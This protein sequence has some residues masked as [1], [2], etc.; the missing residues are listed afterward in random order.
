MTET[1]NIKTSSQQ[2]ACFTLLKE[3]GYDV[4]LNVPYSEC[5][6][7][8]LIT[9]EDGT[10]IDFEYDGTYWH[11]DMRNRD[12]RRDEFLK[13]AGFKILRIESSRNV[14]TLEQIQQEIDYLME[15]PEHKYTHLNIDLQ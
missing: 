2:L 12:R 7:D 10:K 3:N 4:K 14:P 13:E 1:D 9:M 6:L 5:C 11:K 15:T 8:I